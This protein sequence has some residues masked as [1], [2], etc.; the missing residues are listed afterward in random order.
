LRNIK[1]SPF[2]LR[3]LDDI[4]DQTL[5]K[6]GEQQAEDYLTELWKVIRT[7]ASNLEQN[8]SIDYIRMGYRK[9]ICNLHLIFYRADDETITFVRILHQRMDFKTKL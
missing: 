7:I 4:W 6:W 2:A 1:L 3:D 8:P 5:E 9:A